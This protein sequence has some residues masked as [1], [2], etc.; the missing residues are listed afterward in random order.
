MYQGQVVIEGN[1]IRDPEEV[2]IGE[3]ATTMA[4]FGIAVN[5]YFKNAQA[6][7]VEEMMCI[8]IQVW[9]SLAKSCLQYLQKGRGVRVVGRLMQ[10]RWQ[11][12]EQAGVVA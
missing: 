9:G 6:E 8:T 7:P 5:R 4:K 10:E 12:Q 3:N 11:Q 2:V 1:L